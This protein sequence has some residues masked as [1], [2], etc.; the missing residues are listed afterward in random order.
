MYWVEIDGEHIEDSCGGLYGKEEV[1]EFILD[2]FDAKYYECIKQD[3]EN[4]KWCY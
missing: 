4:I 3:F 2:N 1:L